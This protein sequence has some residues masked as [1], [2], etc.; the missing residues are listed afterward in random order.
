MDVSCHVTIHMKTIVMGSPECT[1]LPFAQR[2]L[3]WAPVDPCLSL[4][5][6]KQVYIVDG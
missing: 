6:Q 4:N 3:G 2:E 5:K 1:P